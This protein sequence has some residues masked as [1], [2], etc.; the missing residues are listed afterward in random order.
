MEKDSAS[1]QGRLSGTQQE[2]QLTLG[3]LHLLNK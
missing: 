2:G 1:C 3:E